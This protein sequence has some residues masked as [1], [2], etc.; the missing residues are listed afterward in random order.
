MKPFPV[1]LMNIDKAFV[2][3][4]LFI[5]NLLPCISQVHILKNIVTKKDNMIIQAK[6][7]VTSGL[8]GVSQ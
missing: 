8:V 5:K 2:L 1:S 6:L 4:F 7:A 3:N